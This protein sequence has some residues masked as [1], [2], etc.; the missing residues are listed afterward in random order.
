MNHCTC[1]LGST[2]T[3]RLS[4]YVVGQERNSVVS[5]A[6][7]SDGSLPARVLLSLSVTSRLPLHLHT[8]ADTSTAP[9][10]TLSYNC[11]RFPD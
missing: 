6:S 2:V 10:W 4:N 3:A 11:G 8:G 9:V 1:L 5:A 7:L